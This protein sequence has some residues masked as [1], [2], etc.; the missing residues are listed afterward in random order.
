EV[1]DANESTYASDVYSFGIVVW[2]AL[3]R[4]L[5]WAT[6][7]RP[8]DIFIRVVE[9]LRPVIPDCHDCAPDKSADLAMACWAGKRGDR[10]TIS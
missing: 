9:E 2:E 5:P 10:P 3:S 4:E 6:L 8:K 1:L 7:I